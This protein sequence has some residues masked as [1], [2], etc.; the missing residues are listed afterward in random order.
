MRFKNRYLLVELL[1][2]DGRRERQNVR[3]TA[4]LS[5]I[6]EGIRENFGEYGEA[7]MTSS[8]QGMSNSFC[9]TD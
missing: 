8:L 7:C 4:I 3:E 5:A 6:R 1:W 2:C 9:I